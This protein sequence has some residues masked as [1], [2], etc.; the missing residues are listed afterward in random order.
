MLPK[1]RRHTTYVRIYTI[2]THLG[3]VQGMFRVLQGL[4]RVPLYV[5]YTCLWSRFLATR[6]FLS[7]PCCFQVADD[8]DDDDDDEDDDTYVATGSLESACA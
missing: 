5:L 6:L 4:F 2:Y 8:D 3:F 7:T 1:M